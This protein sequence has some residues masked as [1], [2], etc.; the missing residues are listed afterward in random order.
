METRHSQSSQLNLVRI[1]TA[2]TFGKAVAR[3]LAALGGNVQEQESPGTEIP[4]PDAWPAAD[5]Y[6]AAAWRPVSR[7]CQSLSEHAFQT[8]TPFIP[9]IVDSSILRVGPVIV[10]GKS[11][12]WRC[13]QLRSQQHAALPR[14]Q[15]ELLRF[16]E[17]NPHAGPGG[18]LEPFAAMGAARIASVIQSQSHLQELAGHIWQIH[19]FTKEV[20]TSFLIGID[21]CAWC[22][23][24]RPFESRTY[25][26]IQ[27][28][29][30]FL[31]A[32]GMEA[33]LQKKRE[34]ERRAYGQD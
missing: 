13:W 14:E 25:A 12:C 8:R 26:G 7:L 31:R 23:L 30:A 22:G 2:G 11:G 15:A 1:V 10:P 4:A 19:L 29:L 27:E 24:G 34:K 16:Y 33:G 6:I 32:N 28:E 5:I 9:L 21:G 17:N 20:S 18:Y 3:S